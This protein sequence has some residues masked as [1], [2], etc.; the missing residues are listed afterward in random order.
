VRSRHVEQHVAPSLRPYLPGNPEVLIYG[1]VIPSTSYRI[2]SLSGRCDHCPRDPTNCIRLS[3][4]MPRRTAAHWWKPWRQERALDPPVAPT[5]CS[6]AWFRTTA[7]FRA[8]T[9]YSPGP[10]PCQ[11]P[12]TGR[13]GRRALGVSRSF[14]VDGPHVAECDFP[15]WKPACSWS[16]SL[17]GE[18][19]PPTGPKALKR[20]RPS[21]TVIAAAAP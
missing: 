15:F 11:A 20:F 16:T 14:S 1:A 5:P 2:S 7:A 17:T 8:R 21:R 3:A 18:E 6:T 12:R 9:G 4:P 10:S 13:P 19:L